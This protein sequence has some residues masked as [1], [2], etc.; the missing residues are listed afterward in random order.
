MIDITELEKMAKEAGLEQWRNGYYKTDC[1]LMHIHDGLTCIYENHF[2]RHEQ[3]VSEDNR[4][5]PIIGCDENGPIL[6]KEK[7]AFIAAVDP[8]T[9]LELIMRLQEA[10]AAGLPI[11]NAPKG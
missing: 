5:T 1:Y 9:I 4:F 6:S 7:A 11:E 10:E 3:Y 2:F 8:I